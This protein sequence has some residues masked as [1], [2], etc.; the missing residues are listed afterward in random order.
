MSISG[1]GGIGGRLTW[2]RG[3]LLPFES[4]WSTFAKVM[5]LNLLDWEEIRVMI[6]TPRARS[7]L[8][9]PELTSGRWIDIARYASLLGEPPTLIE[10]GFLDQLG[11]PTALTTRR[12]IRH[13]AE[14]VAFGYHCSLFAMNSLTHCPWHGVRLSSPCSGCEKTVREMDWSIDTEQLRCPNCGRLLLDRSRF[15]QLNHL[16]PAL[17]HDALDCCN[18]IVDWWRQVREREEHANPLFA[19]VLDRYVEERDWIHDSYLRVGS[20]TAIVAPPAFLSFEGPATPGAVSNWRACQASE[21][22]GDEVDRTIKSSYRS[23]RRKIFQTYVRPH[24]RCLAC[25]MAMNR[26]EWLF[27]DRDYVCTTCVAYVAWR[28]AHEGGAKATIG[29]YSYENRRPGATF[30]QHGALAVDVA[31]KIL[32]AD[33]LRLLMALEADDLSGNLK[34]VVSRDLRP[35]PKAVTDLFRVPLP[36]VIVSSTGDIRGPV[37]LK[38]IVP[39]GNYLAQRAKER[40]DARNKQ[41]WAMTGSNCSLFGFGL[42]TAWSDIANSD[43]LFKLRVYDRWASRSYTILQI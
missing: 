36:S 16:R 14:C 11:F 43:V 7:R 1:A 31:S 10:T 17:S 21:S 4:A 42:Q 34:I 23:V 12:G 6:A 37:E 29:R 25:L 24:R 28:H 2:P 35:M 27:L 32:Y 5:A 26:Y 40:C 18:Q 39:D 19:S 13:C 33:Y 38:V 3:T 9:K 20:L 8:E 41:G 30:C 15:F 22:V